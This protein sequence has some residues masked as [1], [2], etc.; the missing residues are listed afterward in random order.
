MIG[1][2]KNMRRSFYGGGIMLRGVL[3]ATWNMASVKQ[4]AT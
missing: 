1:N 3:R 2:G 4:P